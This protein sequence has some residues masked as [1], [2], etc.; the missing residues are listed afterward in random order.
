M[1]AVLGLFN[2]QQTKVYP[3]IMD[4]MMRAM[5]RWGPDGSGTWLSKNI[6]LGQYLR[7]NTPE[8]RFEK[9]P[10]E[11]KC[12]RFVLLS[13]ARLDNRKKLLDHFRIPVED[14][15]VTPDSD[16][17][18]EAYLKWGADAVHHLLGDWAFAVWDK[19]KQRLFIARDHHGNTGIYYFHNHDFF[20]FS[21]GF[22]GLR[23]LPAI[24]QDLD[25]M[26]IAQLLTVWPGNGSDTMFKGIKRLPPAHALTI[27]HR[28]VKIYQYWALE[29]TPDIRFSSDS[30]YVDA[31]NDL[32]HKAVQC[33]LRSNSPVG[34][35]LSGG[36]D[37]GS[38]ATVAAKK[39]ANEGKSLTAFCAAPIFDISDSLP[40]NRFNDP[41]YAQSTAAAAGINDLVLV[42]SEHLNPLQGL[43]QGLKV[44]TEPVHAAANQ[45]WLHSM[46][47]EA[48]QR[49]ITTL[50]TG[51]GGNYSISWHGGGYLAQLAS[52]FHW[53][54]LIRELSAMGDLGRILPIINHQIIRPLIPLRLRHHFRSFRDRHPPW[55]N[56]SAINNTFADKL[57]L[58]GQMIKKGHNTRFGLGSSC[59]ANQLSGIKPGRDSAG[60]RLQQLGAFYGVELRDP[61]MDKRIIEFC[62]A[63][64]DNQFIRNG[65]DRFLIR[66]AMAGQMPPD[67]LNSSMRG[68]Q[69]VDIYK[70]LKIIT[71]QLQKQLIRIESSQKVKEI[72]DINRLHTMVAH[73]KDQETVT[74]RAQQQA[75]TLLRSLM[76]G[77]FLYGYEQTTVTQAPG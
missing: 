52:G 66:R 10:L 19:V 30:E 71:D 37:S 41:D 73:L 48:Q 4:T 49:G 17:I 8:A 35:T 70:R 32:F 67:V 24:P 42:K 3:E 63:I 43:V 53:Q 68:L 72:L 16:L 1:S 44:H 59:R 64:P 13:R 36:L 7:F 65:K 51:M 69:S 76:A 5:A 45:Y 34:V 6:G 62:F 77:L 27:D 58:L 15:P 29:N 26:A 9:L 25:E 31:F 14:H 2:L 55:N 47:R 12:G 33:R 74:P 61:T 46:L 18:L 75:G 50:L 38:V 40:P 57:D 54:T 39:L 60:C 23:A 11:S 21:S 28:G 56:Y 22:A 20:A